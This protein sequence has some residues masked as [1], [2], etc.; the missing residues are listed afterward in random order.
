MTTQLKEVANL[1]LDLEESC[2]ITWMVAG[3]I[4]SLNGNIPAAIANM[5]GMRIAAKELGPDRL[6]ALVERMNL[7]FSSA[8]PNAEF[9]REDLKIGECLHCRCDDTQCCLCGELK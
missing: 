3:N 7:L 2:F 4:A 1:T 8:F 6:N 5:L 9:I